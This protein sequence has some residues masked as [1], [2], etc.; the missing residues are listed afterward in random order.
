MHIADFE[1][2]TT[3]ILGKSFLDTF[4]DAALIYWTG[5]RHSTLREVIVGGEV[6]IV[7]KLP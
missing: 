2:I 4:V 3:T 7:A 5:A 1:A 6:T